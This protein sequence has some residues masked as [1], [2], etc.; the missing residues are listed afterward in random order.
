LNNLHPSLA[1]ELRQGISKSADPSARVFP[2]NQH[3]CRTFAK[4]LKRAKIERFA[5]M[6]RKLDFHALRYTSTRLA[7]KGVSQ[8]LTQELRRHSDAN[9]TA[10]VYTGA[11]QLPTFD[12]VASLD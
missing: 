12:A 7:L 10:K 11:S 6:K 2:V 5:A 3:M 1:A 8:R 4:D 9:L